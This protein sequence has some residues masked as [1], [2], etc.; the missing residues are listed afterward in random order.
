MIAGLADRARGRGEP[1]G[2]RTPIWHRLDIS[3]LLQGASSDLFSWFMKSFFGDGGEGVSSQISDV[4]SVST[5]DPKYFCPS[6]TFWSRDQ[7]LWLSDILFC[8]T[9]RYQVVWLLSQDLERLY[10]IQ[11]EDSRGILLQL[12]GGKKRKK[13]SFYASVWPLNLLYL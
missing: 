4:M 8:L 3:S 10:A 6:C 11:Y 7:P 12:C 2:N 9:F 13:G 5:S 1:G